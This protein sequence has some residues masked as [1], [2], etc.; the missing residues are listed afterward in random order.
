MWHLIGVPS[1][2]VNDSICLG[3]EDKNQG[4]MV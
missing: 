1:L 2:K 4:E 3:K